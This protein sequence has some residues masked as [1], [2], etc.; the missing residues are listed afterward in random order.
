MV[1]KDY[2]GEGR[3]YAEP[4]T[5]SEGYE[6]DRQTL[7]E[8][9]YLSGLTLAERVHNANEILF[10]GP[11]NRINWEETDRAR[12]EKARTLL[13]PGSYALKDHRIV[14][15]KGAVLRTTGL[16]LMRV[17]EID[18]AYSLRNQTRA[19]ANEGKHSKAKKAKV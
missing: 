9:N 15:V 10:R 13:P 11:D 1:G 12:S 8:I 6:P 4:Y 17:K 19:A 2:A 7:R 16:A 3:G 14:A 5:V 18:Q